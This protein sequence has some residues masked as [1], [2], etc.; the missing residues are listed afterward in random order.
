MLRRCL[1]AGIA[2]IVLIVGVEWYRGRAAPAPAVVE[3]RVDQQAG[4][5]EETRRAWRELED[6]SQRRNR[7][8]QFESRLM[9]ALVQRE[10][11]LR[12]A[13]ERLFYYCLEHY[14]EH[15]ENVN[16]AEPGHHIK[17]K[18]AQNMVRSLEV[19]QETAGGDSATVAY[20]Q[21]EMGAL[22]YSQDASTA[23]APH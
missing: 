14:P 5:P 17:M 20:F 2:S 13:T 3:A 22:P 11:S 15:L 1:T 21:C 4:V 16:H 9:Q 19:R 23:P 12:D 18:L 8:R 6:Q 10:I 7:F